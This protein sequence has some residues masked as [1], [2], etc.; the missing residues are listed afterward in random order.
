MPQRWRTQEIQGAQI[1]N[2]ETGE[3]TDLGTI[4]G[5][6]PQQA[7]RKNR[8]EIKFM[9]IDIEAMPKLAMSK[10]EWKLFWQVVSYTDRERG[11]AR[12]T[13]GELA[14][15]IGWN[16]PNTSRALKKM[17]DR[18]ILLKE[19]IGVWRVNPLLMTRKQVEKWEIDMRHAPAIDWEGDEP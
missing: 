10:G 8:R 12:V 4:T 5:L 13:T 6:V 14:K 9:L 17:A 2:T 19:A 7:R 3:V 15:A 1:T 18:N 16:V 11:E